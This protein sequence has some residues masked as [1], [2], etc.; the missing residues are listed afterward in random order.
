MRSK[1]MKQIQIL[2]LLLLIFNCEAQTEETSLDPNFKYTGPEQILYGKEQ[3]LYNDPD[4]LVFQRYKSIKKNTDA[5]KFGQNRIIEGFKIFFHALEFKNDASIYLVMNKTKDYEAL[6]NQFEQ[7]YPESKI[8][9]S[10]GSDIIYKTCKF[11]PLIC[12]LIK[13][14]IWRKGFYNEMVA[15]LKNRMY[16]T[17]AITL[18]KVFLIRIAYVMKKV[19]LLNSSL[20][21]R[22]RLIKELGIQC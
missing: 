15:E 14:A 12:F 16:N 2:F 7:I 9:V 13:A 1:M 8:L 5:C 18:Q 11:Q 3:Y 17:K 10:Q 22:E 19:N 4:F 21:R 6:M 20:D